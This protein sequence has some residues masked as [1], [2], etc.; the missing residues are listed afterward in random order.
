[1]MR[2][3]FL[4]LCL[5]IATA[6]AGNPVPVPE[7]TPPPVVTRNFD[8]NVT[9]DET[10]TQ[11]IVGAVI[12]VTE[13]GTDHVAIT[14]QDGY[15][16]WELP[17]GMLSI[18]VAASGFVTRTVSHT[19]AELAT[20]H[21]CIQLDRAP[22]PI[23]I[24]KEHGYLRADTTIFR[25]DQNAP[26]L[27]A[28]YTI[29]TLLVNVSHGQDINPLLDGPI[30]DGYNTI[31]VLGGF[32]GDWYTQNGF[33]L[34]QRAPEYQAWLR[35]LFDI[36]AS[37]GVRVYL[38]VFQSAQAL[39][40]SEQTAIWNATCDSA[41]GR[42]NVLLGLVN[43]APVNGVDPAQFAPCPNMQG[44]LQSRGSMGINNPPFSPHWDFAEWEPRREPVY[45]AMDDAGAGVLELIHGYTEY[46][47]G[48]NVPVIIGEP[49]FFNEVTPDQYG[50]TRWTDPNLALQLGLNIGAD[51]AGGA[52]GSATGLVALPDT[53]GTVI[54]RQQFLRGLKAAFIR[55]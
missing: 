9:P 19:V 7:P 29:H 27:F 13:N 37:R 43:E 12:T 54:L 38:R 6:C 15:T 32:Y 47:Q 24:G 53:P 8:L 30:A 31:I 52:F 33:A 4:A 44:V 41:R 16:D 20:Q 1:M 39:N 51:S 34:D 3:L 14:N 36:T 21:N 10:C 35:T 17:D 28:G 42:W 49:P 55:P 45:K 46:P 2:K 50:D 40:Q 22:S 18:Q 23:P 25:D 48:V 5:S 26:W 11:K